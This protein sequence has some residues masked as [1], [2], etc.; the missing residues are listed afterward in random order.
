MKKKSRLKD[1]ISGLTHL[2]T[3]VAA[4][5]G[6]FF[7]IQITNAG[8]PERWSAMIYGISCV[9]LFL[10]SSVYHL[11]ITTPKREVFL[12][13]LDH[14]AIFIYIAGTYTP[15]CV[16]LLEGSTRVALLSTVWGI[17]SV[18]VIF[19]LFV[20]KTPRWFSTAIYLA[21]GWSC[22]FAIKPIIEGLTN[23]GVFWLATGGIL[24]T[25]G[26]FVYGTKKFDFKPGV[27]GFH[28]I[29]H[30]FVT[31]ASIAHFILIAGYVLPAK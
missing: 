15:V 24:Y 14:S 30:L 16:V 25:L 23:A 27:F 31:G 1:P 20:F 6:L 22:V 12:R 8:S 17:A 28:E 13:K 26:A 29:W 2:A 18:G 11:W 4:L 10:S 5:I 21:M 9:A 3:A 19:K 7:L